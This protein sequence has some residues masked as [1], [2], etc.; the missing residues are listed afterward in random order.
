MSHAIQSSRDLLYGNS[1]NDDDNS[2]NFEMVV[3]CTESH[4]VIHTARSLDVVQSPAKRTQL[5]NIGV[6]SK[7]AKLQNHI[8]D[9]SC[10]VCSFP[11]I[12]GKPG[13]N[14]PKCDHSIHNKCLKQHSPSCVTV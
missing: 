2:R 10:V 9:E 4:V 12:K 5:L 6:S 8:A 7:R 1:I 14:C 11:S 3:N 13:K